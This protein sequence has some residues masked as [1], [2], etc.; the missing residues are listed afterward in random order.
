MTEKSGNLS[1][2]DMFHALSGGFTNQLDGEKAKESD[3]VTNAILQEIL[4][5]L[6]AQV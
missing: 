6:T 2:S 4:A 3:D 1:L 5:V